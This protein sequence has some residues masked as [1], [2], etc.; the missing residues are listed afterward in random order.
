MKDLAKRGILLSYAGSKGNPGRRLGRRG[1]G[2]VGHH[3]A[4][5]KIS[6]ENRVIKT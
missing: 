4:V 1:E 6:K 5:H 2:A 3:R